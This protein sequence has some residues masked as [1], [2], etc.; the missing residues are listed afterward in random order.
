MELSERITAWRNWKG[1]SQARLASAT[2]LSRASICAIEGNGKSAKKK[3]HHF[4]P[5]VRSLTAIVNAIGVSMSRFY[6]ETP[7]SKRAA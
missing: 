3:G 7:K 2:G 5:S 4:T 1:W 6:G